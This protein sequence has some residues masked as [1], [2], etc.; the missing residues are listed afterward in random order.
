MSIAI[1]CDTCGGQCD[2]RGYYEVKWQAWNGV[3]HDVGRHY[4]GPG[5]LPEV[6]A[7]THRLALAAKEP[8]P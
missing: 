5:C 4:C 2:I 3:G 8:R 7:E 1:K 6:T